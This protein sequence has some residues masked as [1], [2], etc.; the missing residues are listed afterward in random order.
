MSISR[1]L[2]TC[3]CSF[4]C[5]TTWF[6][7]QCVAQSN[8]G[9]NTNYTLKT[10]W[11]WFLLFHFSTACLPAPLLQRQ[12]VPLAV[13]F[14]FSQITKL[15]SIFSHHCKLNFGN[16]LCFCGELSLYLVALFEGNCCTFFRFAALHWI[17]IIQQPSLV[18]IDQPIYSLRYTNIQK[19]YFIYIYILKYIFIWI[20]RF[21]G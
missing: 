21:R 20:F 10:M 4:Y 11:L 7:I 8:Y 13:V 16:L 9:C 18:P 17:I 19:F 2:L 6:H 14:L 1:C 15:F 12:E 5:Q 3:Q